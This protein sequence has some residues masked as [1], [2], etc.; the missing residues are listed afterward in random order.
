MGNPIGA[1]IRIDYN[2]IEKLVKDLYS[3]VRRVKSGSSPEKDVAFMNIMTKFQSA[4]LLTM[5]M[6][7][8][9]DEPSAKK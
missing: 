4:L 1:R 3:D 9:K 7:V 5:K 6:E 2:S 8:V